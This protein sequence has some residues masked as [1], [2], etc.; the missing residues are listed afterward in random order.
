M[1]GFLAKDF[2]IRYAKSVENPGSLG[3]YAV[4]LFTH[5]DRGDQGIS[6]LE[7]VLEYLVRALRVTHSEKKRLV[8]VGAVEASFC[9]LG[10]TKLLLDAPKR[11]KATYQNH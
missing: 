11:K 9:I 1:S 8:H 7:I 10:P 2:P 6:V 5:F 3:S 4:S